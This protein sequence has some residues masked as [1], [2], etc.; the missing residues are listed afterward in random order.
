MG[1]TGTGKSATTAWLTERLQRPML[2]MVPDKTLAA[3]LANELREML[4]HDAVEYFVSYYDYYP[5]EAYIAQ[6]ELHRERHLDQRRRRAAS[7]LGHVRLLSRRD[8]VVVAS[9][10]CIYGVGHPGSP[11]GPVDRAEVG[12]MC[13]ATNCCDRLS[14]RN[15]SATTWPSPR[16]SFRARGDTVDIFRPTRNRCP[17]RVPRRRSR[18]AVLHA[19]LTGE[20]VRKVDSLRVFPATH[21][22]AGPER[23]RTRF[24]PSNRN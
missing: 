3:Q 1:A 23:W 17:H 20:V 24:R 6:T 19:S 22:V 2:V 14:T 12:E 10:S 18:S 21:Y 4:P 11:I 7:T 13:H 16:G 15:T 8:V 9:V 5:P